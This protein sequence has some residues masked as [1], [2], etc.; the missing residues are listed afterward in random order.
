MLHVAC[1]ITQQL[2]RGIRAEQRQWEMRPEILGLAGITETAMQECMSE[3]QE[4]LT[5]LKTRLRAA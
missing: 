4:A 1:W 3:T 5:Q 2:G